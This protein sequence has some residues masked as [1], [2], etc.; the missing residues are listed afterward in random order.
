MIILLTYA[1]GW[2]WKVIGKIRS[3]SK[4]AIIGQFVLKLAIYHMIRQNWA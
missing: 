3:C 4:D 1:I 2:K